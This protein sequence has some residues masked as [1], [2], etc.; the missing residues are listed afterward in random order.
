MNGRQEQKNQKHAQLVSGTTGIKRTRK[1][2]MKNDLFY[3]KR[4][5]RSN[6]KRNIL[7]INRGGDSQSYEKRNPETKNLIIYNHGIKPDKW[8]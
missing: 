1:G 6:Q 4:K 8:R 5:I 3:S 2:K 7:Y